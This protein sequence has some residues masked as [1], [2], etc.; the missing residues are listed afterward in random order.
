MTPN[1]NGWVII[2]FRICILFLE[3][4]GPYSG[5]HMEILFI[6]LIVLI[7]ILL[8][9]LNVIMHKQLKASKDIEDAIYRLID[10]TKD[11]KK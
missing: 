3:V 9:N 2:K 7:I 11:A 4:R 5:L 10:L 8:L 1:Y 6:L